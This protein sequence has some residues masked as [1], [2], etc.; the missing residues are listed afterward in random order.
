MTGPQWD[1]PKALE[2]QSILYKLG[3]AEKVPADDPRVASMRVVDTMWTGRCKRG[4]N[5]EITQLKAR[6]VM[7]GDLQAKFYTITAKKR[8]RLSY[9]TRPY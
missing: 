3:A 2:V 1:E 4:P 5:G 7:R 8:R 9:G 6:C